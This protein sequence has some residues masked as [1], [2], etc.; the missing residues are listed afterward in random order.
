MSFYLTEQRLPAVESYTAGTHAEC[1]RHKITIMIIL[2]VALA[3]EKT[4]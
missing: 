1:G 3:C 2:L 4:I